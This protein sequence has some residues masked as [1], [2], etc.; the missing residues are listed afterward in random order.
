LLSF[1]LVSFCFISFHF[2]LF[3]LKKIGSFSKVI[4]GRHENLGPLVYD[5]CLHN[6]NF[7]QKE[8]GFLTSMQAAWD[9]VGDQCLGKRTTLA[10]WLEVHA[11]CMRHT[12]L[13]G[14]MRNKE[15]SNFVEVPPR[16]PNK[17]DGITADAIK[18]IEAE[19]TY[20]G[21]ARPH[22]FS[23]LHVKGTKERID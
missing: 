10:M 6:Q 15:R 9:F 5:E 3:F 22:F 21:H 13:G 12:G 14:I 19:A 8:V 7:G 11:L 1:H 17:P 18:E 2:F 23:L 20:A 4:D 16:W